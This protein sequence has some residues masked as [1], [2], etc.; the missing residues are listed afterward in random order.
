MNPPFFTRDGGEP[1]THRPMHQREMTAGE[2]ARFMEALTWTL[3]NA[4][5]TDAV[6]TNGVVA[7]RV[8]A[9]DEEGGVLTY[10]PVSKP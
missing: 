5:D 3:N 9:D 7:L 1:T 8:W 2:T 10:Q 6:E 4:V